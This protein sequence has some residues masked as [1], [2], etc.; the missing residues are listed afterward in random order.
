M[1]PVNPTTAASRRYKIQFTISMA[2]YVVIICAV[3]WT[4]NHVELHGVLQY[5]VTLAPCI[6]I[7]F[8]IKAIERYFRDSD[9]LERRILTEA[10]A[11]GAAGTAIISLTYGFLEN[12]GLPHLSA[13]WTFA[14]V[15]A[16]TGLA[17][18]SLNRRYE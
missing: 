13:W 10:L 12:A 8:L 5:L 2:A 6:P 16:L 9:E 11:V 1:T 3:T 15:M 18:I 14:T 4:L 7:G 17:R